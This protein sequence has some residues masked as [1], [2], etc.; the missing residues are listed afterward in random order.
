LTPDQEKDTRLPEK[1]RRVQ[2]LG[3]R[4]PR[5][6]PEAVSI[7]L[8]LERVPTKWNQFDME[9]ERVEIEKVEQFFLDML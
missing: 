6:P 8:R 5:G 9:L 4:R 7:R 2:I 3:N 1:Q